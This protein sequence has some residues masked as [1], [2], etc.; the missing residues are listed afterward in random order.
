MSQRIQGTAS[1]ILKRA[2]IRLRNSDHEIEFLIPM[3]DAA[4]FQ[5]PKETAIE[6]KDIIQTAFEEEFVKECPS[7]KVSAKFKSFCED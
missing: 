1:L 5:V 7:L 6:K 4:L 2:I 3:H